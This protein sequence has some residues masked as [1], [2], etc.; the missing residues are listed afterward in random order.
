[1]C[2]MEHP[3]QNLH[4]ELS[5]LVQILPGNPRTYEFMRSARTLDSVCAPPLSC[6]DVGASRSEPEG[7]TRVLT[8]EPTRRYGTDCVAREKARNTPG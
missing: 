1:L 7:T 4:S 2:K 8:R 5:Y 6:F 3:A